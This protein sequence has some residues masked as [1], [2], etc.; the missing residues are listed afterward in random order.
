MTAE[1]FKKNFV[2]NVV[3]FLRGSTFG[4]IYFVALAGNISCYAEDYHS[5]E[6]IIQVATNVSDGLYSPSEVVNL[7]KEKGIKIIFFNDSLFRK[8]K[9][10]IQPFEN[11][12]KITKEEPSVFRYGIKK[13]LKEIED[14]NK[15]YPDMAIFAGVEAY[16][17][18]WWEGS[19]LKG[20][21][22]N[23]DLNKHLF[24]FGLTAKDYEFLPVIAKRYIMPQNFKSFILFVISILAIFVG[25]RLLRLR[26]RRL[27][28]LGYIIFIFGILFLL[29]GFP[30]PSKYDAYHGDK[31]YKP[32]QEFIGYVKKRGGFVF[33]AHPGYEFSRSYGKVE[34]YTLKY[35]DVLTSTFDYD[36]FGGI[37]PGGASS[38]LAGKEWDIILKEF[39]LGQRKMPIWAT[40][41]VDFDGTT[42]AKIN[43]IQTVF[44]LKRLDKDS[45]LESLRNGRFYCRSYRDDSYVDLESFTL[46]D[47]M[48]G[49]F[50]TVKNNP[51]LV[52]KGVVQAN[53]NTKIRLEIIRSGDIVKAY[54]ILKGRFDLEFIGEE[55]QKITGKSYYR[56]NFFSGDNLILASNPIFYEAK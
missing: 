3:S 52:I 12:I 18:Y 24:V 56:I 51:K 6:G 16:P 8:V 40:G 19:P 17:F 45:I 39:C 46:Q 23:F 53:P 54:E 42:T 48:M 25:I 31:G 13:Y 5:F 27:S 10:G 43:S 33:W 7:A 20:K 41:E 21:L 50:V 14:L 36:G 11:L 38:C 35:P 55:H 47:R 15:R 9:Y 4:I 44:F 30:F 37:F 26:I 2:P 28:Y 1:C 34:L 49:E 29:N 32:Y 22:F